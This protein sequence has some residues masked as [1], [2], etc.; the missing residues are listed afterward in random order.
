MSLTPSCPEFESPFCPAHSCY[1]AAHP[2]SLRVVAVIRLTVA[3]TQCCVQEALAYLAVAPE[4]ESRDAGAQ[5][6]PENSREVLP[7]SEN[8]SAV[9]CFERSHSYN[10]KYSIL[11]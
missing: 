2:Q 7:F 5:D 6:M 10:F 8:V 3:V 4:G 1:A 9:W 11:L